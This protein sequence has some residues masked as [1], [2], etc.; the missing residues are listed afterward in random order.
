MPMN[1]LPIKAWQK[2][3]LKLV[4]KD[5]G[6]VNCEESIDGSWQK[7]E[8]ILLNGVVTAMSDGNV[9]MFMFYL[10]IVKD[11]EFGNKKRTYLNIKNGKLPIRVI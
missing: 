2:L 1:K 8:H 7:R 10:N 3:R 9:F 4:P 5:A 6:L 11:G